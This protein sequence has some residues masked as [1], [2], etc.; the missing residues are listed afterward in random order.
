MLKILGLVAV[1]SAF[2]VNVAGLATAEGQG[3]AIPH[4]IVPGVYSFDSGGGYHSM[5]V[6]TDDWVA[7]FETV[8]SQPSTAMLEAIK[9]V[10]D[11][12]D[13]CARYTGTIPVVEA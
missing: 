7:A 4:E 9:S 1:T 12:P 13:K 5:F 3:N 2:A 10:T 11:Q 6:V 8:D